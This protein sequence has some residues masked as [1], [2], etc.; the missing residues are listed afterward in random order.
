MNIYYSPSATGFFSTVLYRIDQLPDDAIA[1]SPELHRALLEGASA[2]KV[3][4][5]G[6]DGQPRLADAPARAIDYAALIAEA[7]YEREVSGITA[8]GFS[9]DTSDRSKTL[10]TGSA[11]NASIDPNYT[12]SWKSPTGFV[13][14]SGPQVIAI[15]KAV[16]AHVQACFDREEALLAALADGSFTPGMLL[17]GWPA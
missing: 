5:I 11:F 12:L 2:G 16:S 7:R 13:E 6:S 10:I 17:E 3:I 1:I 4:V 8:G 9:V 14:L 15:A